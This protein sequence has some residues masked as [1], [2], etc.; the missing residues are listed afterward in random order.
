M[1]DSPV[2]IQCRAAKVSGSYNPSELQNCVKCEEYEFKQQQVVEELKS[3]QLIVQMLRN[4][5]IHE[6][7][8][9]ATIHQTRP[10]LVTNDSWKEISKGSHKKHFKGKIEL[11]NPYKYQIKMINLYSALESEWNI[12]GDDISPET[13]LVNKT[14]VMN[15]K[16][17]G[18]KLYTEQE[19]LARN[20]ARDELDI[21]TRE[22]PNLQKPTPSAK[23]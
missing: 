13:A 5:H 7:Y 8:D 16:Q 10:D 19:C 11:R 22:Q 18:N 12:S 15:T 2:E 9:V 3:V 6:D 20:K 1:A 17:L 23:N 14:K 21:R 4:E